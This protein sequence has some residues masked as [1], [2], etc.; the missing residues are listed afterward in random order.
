[1]SGEDP[2]HVVGRVCLVVL[3]AAEREL[4]EAGISDGEFLKDD[5]EQFVRQ[6]R[7]ALLSRQRL[8][9]GAGVIGFERRRR[10]PLDQIVEMLTRD[11]ALADQPGQ[12]HRAR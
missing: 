11:A 6:P 5:I 8:E 9:H 1:M 12:P 2:A 4:D 10:Q 3:E 7:A